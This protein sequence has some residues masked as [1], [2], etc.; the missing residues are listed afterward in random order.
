MLAL[1]GA[2]VMAGGV[3]IVSTEL[4]DNGDDDGFADTLETVHLRLV[5]Q[6]TTG[7]AQTNVVMRL[8]TET[9][10]IACVGRPLVV[11]GDLAAGETRLTEA[12]VLTVG[13]VDRA[14]LG[15]GELDDLSAQFEVTVFS[16]QLASFARAPVL[17][18]DLDLDVTGGAGA[19]TF[20]EGFESGDLASFT[21][22]N[23]DAGRSSLSGSDEFRCQYSDPDWT[24]SNSYGHITDCFLGATAQQADAT[25]WQVDGPG[26]DPGW[27]GRGFSG[28]HSLY[29][30]I[31]L[32]PA[33]GHTTPLA[34]LEAT[35]T[36]DPINIGWGRVCEGDGITECVDDLGCP[37][38]DSCVAT[39]PIVTF[40]HQVS[41]YNFRTDRTTQ[42]DRG[43]VQVQLADESGQPV[44]PWIKVEPYLNP[45]DVQNVSFV[46]NCFFDPAD[47]GNTEDDFFDPTNPERRLGPSS[48]CYPE[49]TFGRTGDTF[50]PFDSTRLRYADGP[51]L[52]G[53][54]GLGTWVES[55]FDLSRFR[56]RRVRVRFLVTS[57]KAGGI[58]S[59]EVAYAFNPWSE[60][61]GWW[62]DDFE[63]GGV[64][65]SPATVQADIKA[66]DTLPG[67]GDGDGDGL[68][69]ACDTCPDELD[70][71]QGDLDG[72]GVG[73]LCDNCPAN[74]NPDQLDSD[75]DGL[76][77]ACDRCPAGDG[78]DDDGDGLGCSS[79]NCLDEPNAGQSDQDADGFG[80]A[81]D[82]C[83]LDPENDRD[84][85]GVCEEIDS[86]PTGYNADQSPTV[87]ISA[88]LGLDADVRDFVASPDGAT[89][90]YLADQDLDEMFELYATPVSGGEP[91]RLGSTYVPEGDVYDHGIAISPDSSRVVYLADLER[92]T[93]NELY[94]VP[95]D[96]QTVPVK[97]S[98]SMVPGGNVEWWPGTLISPDG[99]TVVYL[100]DQD[101]LDQ[102][103]LYGVPIDGGT[104]VSLTSGTAVSIDSFAISPD[105]SRVVYADG[106]SNG[107]DLFSVPV[108][109]GERVRL[110]QVGTVLP[111]DGYRI[112]PVGPTVVFRSDEEAAGVYELYRTPVEGG[113]PV[114]V[115]GTLV[116]GSGVSVF[117]LGP[118]GATVFYHA[119][120]ELTG[121]GT[122]KIP[123]LGG[124]PVRVLD[125]WP[126]FSPDGRWMIY[127]DSSGNLYSKQVESQIPIWLSSSSP[128]TWDELSI[129]P[130]SST[131]VYLSDG[132]LRSVPIDGGAVVRLDG[133]LPENFYLSGFEIS[134]DSSAVVYVASS[135]G[136]W[137]YGVP[138]H[139]GPVVRLHD[140][141]LR[142]TYGWNPGWDFVPHS[143][144]VIFNTP[145]EKPDVHELFVTLLEPDTDADGTLETCDACPGVFNPVQADTDGDGVGDLCD[146]C[147][148][149][150]NY[151][152]A[153]LDLDGRGD[154]CDCQPTDPDVLRPAEIGRLD[155]DLSLTGET[156]LSWVATRGAERYSVTRGS[157]SSLT[158]TEYG[159]CLAEGLLATDFADPGMPAP[160][161][162][163]G[164]LVQAQ[165]LECGLGSLGFSSF[166]TER[167]NADAAACVGATASVA[168]PGGKSPI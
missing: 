104:S 9:P 123:L 145:E 42:M 149:T 52:E 40:K 126:I 167:D 60:E 47:D 158:R 88:D 55:K 101:T 74:V 86:C 152:Q 160:G 21:S 57:M 7:V 20:F 16:D 96:G 131:V 85:D 30:G 118:D 43:V 168:A 147:P 44:G 155:V 136:N 84:G 128:T 25:Y 4:S 133:P 111:E 105:S 157:L 132:A 34:V 138:I 161:D 27:P 36:G 31:E 32:D 137:L 130:D 24:G 89:V 139:G 35:R 5:L 28:S 121:T 114:K 162:G 11:V 80:D 142:G 98:G 64:L 108:G 134:P 93:F 46:F 164:Y 109:G 87:R 12:F 112:S 69:D 119:Q 62:I 26:P 163:F 8:S 71:G 95:L 38:G 58:E 23:L 70:P 120:D 10:E 103:D 78:A 68:I 150:A 110:N 75:M 116:S 127:D 41:L 92:V 141:I 54:T 79:D 153:D 15:L 102:F 76:G 122:Y 33:L 82:A 48:T 14:S 65:T 17:T 59:W 1:L 115:N 61:D 94:S 73:D 56:G 165:S 129:S 72:D 53:E 151:D 140:S 22:Q 113:I 83:P 159:A 29:Y 91:I 117:H 13:D 156:L 6:N 166:E 2:P 107:V 50:D 148:D 135:D 97:I 63:V 125:T 77:E 67:F 143:S 37:I 51:G 154:T 100:A 99:S 124:T 144:A 106:N 66:N 18:L 19:T 49:W 81:C 90:V 39:R 146:N 45:Y 3:A